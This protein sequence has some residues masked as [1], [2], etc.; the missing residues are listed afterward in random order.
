M[1][2]RLRLSMLCCGQREFRGAGRVNIEQS[3]SS[4]RCASLVRWQR[5]ACSG[6]TD[7]LEPRRDAGKRA[8]IHPTV[9]KPPAAPA[10][11]PAI[12]PSAQPPAQ[13]RTYGN[14]CTDRRRTNSPGDRAAENVR[15]GNCFSRR[16]G[17]DDDDVHRQPRRGAGGRARSRSLG[18]AERS[19][20]RATV[21]IAGCNKIRKTAARARLLA[22]RV[23]NVEKR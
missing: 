6:R 13:K 18:W 1:S 12:M 16:V 4:T 22:Q 8:S 9:R 7:G 19:D 14:H 17:D 2:A 20:K 23:I 11:R 5:R 15:K 10:R 3:S 21:C